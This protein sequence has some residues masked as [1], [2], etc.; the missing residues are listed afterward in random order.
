MNE[1]DKILINAYLDGET[2]EADSKY[3]ESLIE[4]S[5]Q[6]NEYANKIKRANNEI[7]TFFNSNDTQ[8][9]EASINTF[10]QNHKTKQSRPFSFFSYQK[11]ISFAVA[12]S[13][14]VFIAIPN[15]GDT[16]PEYNF[17]LE[18]SE[19]LNIEAVIDQTIDKMLADEV[20][21]AVAIVG[22]ERIK[23]I[24]KDEDLNCLYGSASYNSE[25][26]DFNY[27]F[28]TDNR[29]SFD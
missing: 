13:L 1:N 7:N 25:E 27:C 19:N 12:A 22:N 2:S 3:V 20:N 8:A 24:I 17:N 4:S 10:I 15:G 11:V 6:A 18:R 16:L 9:L 26:L 5:N 29:L 21:A 28:N 14:V 23:V